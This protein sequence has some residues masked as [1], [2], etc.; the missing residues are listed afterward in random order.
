MAFQKLTPTYKLVKVALRRK[1]G[2][3]TTLAN[4]LWYSQSHISN[5]L[6]GRR[7]NEL[8]TNKAYRMSRNRS[9]MTS[10]A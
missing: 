1:R 8:V 7:S 10:V 2:D 9:S 5:V 6:A 4:Q 3:I